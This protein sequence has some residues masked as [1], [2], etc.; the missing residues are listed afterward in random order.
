MRYVGGFRDGRIGFQNEL[1]RGEPGLREGVGV[2]SRLREWLFSFAEKIL[3]ESPQGQSPFGQSQLAVGLPARWASAA[4]LLSGKAIKLVDFELSS[5]GGIL[6][7]TGNQLRGHS[8]LFIS[9]ARCQ[10]ER[11]Y[12]LTR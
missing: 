4:S 2:F 5:G 10:S 9:I 7:T 3:R 12:R 11:W 8:G 6:L 1:G